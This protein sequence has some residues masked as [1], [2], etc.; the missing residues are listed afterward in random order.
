MTQNIVR[1]SKR[2]VWAGKGVVR[3]PVRKRG[4]GN[5]KKNLSGKFPYVL[6][7]LIVITY[8]AATQKVKNVA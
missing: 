4:K 7:P 8:G 1:S 2:V 6:I 5:K 3:A